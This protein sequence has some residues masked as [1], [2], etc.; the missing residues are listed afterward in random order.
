MFLNT[1]QRPGTKSIV[2]SLVQN[3]EIE[4]YNPGH[5]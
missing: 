2:T 4:G 1:I 5:G 3:R